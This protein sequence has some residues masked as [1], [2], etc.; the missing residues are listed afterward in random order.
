MVKLLER[1]P[2]Q[3]PN[4]DDDDPLDSEKMYMSDVYF[5]IIWH[6]I[7]YLY[8]EKEAI[9][10]YGKVNN[11]MIELMQKG[12]RGTI[13]LSTVPIPIFEQQIQNG[14]ENFHILD[15]RDIEN[16]TEEVVEME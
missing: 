6:N 16:I 10:V 3:I 8:D 13:I 4:D 11:R 14:V 1:K 9:K 15:L 2:Y 7:G 12:R 5:D